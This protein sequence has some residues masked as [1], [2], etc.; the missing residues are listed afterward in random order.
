M[1][2]WDPEPMLQKLRKHSPCEGLFK[3]NL[4]SAE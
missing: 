3:F 2:L 4:R 1:W